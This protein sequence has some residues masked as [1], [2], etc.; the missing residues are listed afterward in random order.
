MELPKS[1]R[2]LCASHSRLS[3]WAGLLCTALLVLAAGLVLFTHFSQPLRLL[4]VASG[5][6]APLISK[7][8]AVV[9][10]RSNPVDIQVG[11]I[12]SYPSPRDSSLVVTHRVVQVF[13]ETGKL[14]TQGDANV[15]ADPA[16]AASRVMGT[17]RF[18]LA[19]AGRVVDFIHSWP[20]LVLTVYLPMALILGRE[21]VRLGRYY[22]RPTYIR[23]G[24]LQ[25]T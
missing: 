2:A 6:M 24:Y 1:F 12:V 23:R 4:S 13:P 25:R 3:H 18:S 20:G 21:L 8:D 5:S 17:V 9:V 11:D 19:G 16:I 10:Q 7:G 14:V 22:L 15:T